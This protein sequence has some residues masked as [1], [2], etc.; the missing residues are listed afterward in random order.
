MTERSLDSLLDY[1]NDYQG[2]AQRVVVGMETKQGQDIQM[3][4]YF[5][6]GKM[7]RLPRAHVAVLSILDTAF[8]DNLLP[9]AVKTFTDQVKKANVVQQEKDKLQDV[10]VTLFKMV[11]AIKRVPGAEDN[12]CFTKFA[13]VA[14]SYDSEPLKVAMHR[15]AEKEEAAAQHHR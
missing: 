11:E 9:K 13:Q 6:L 14:H 5:M 7:C 15:A 8:A 10:M 1:V 12:M 2:F 4:C 3:L